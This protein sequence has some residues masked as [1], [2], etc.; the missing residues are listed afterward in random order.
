MVR[1]ILEMLLHDIECGVWCAMSATTIIVSLLW[2]YQ[3]MCVCM[4]IY[5]Y[6]HIHIHTYIHTYTHIHTYTYVGCPPSPVAALNI[7][8]MITTHINMQPFA[9]CTLT[10]NLYVCFMHLSTELL[11]GLIT[12]RQ[13]SGSADVRISIPFAILRIASI[14][15]A[16][17]VAV[18]STDVLQTQS[19]TYGK[20]KKSEGVT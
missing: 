16:R 1:V 15:L 6:I 7:Y 18:L 13:R 14:N 19:L 20:R 8:Y 17:K 9:N 4:Y 2:N 11:L 3:F 12:W 10:H 5:I